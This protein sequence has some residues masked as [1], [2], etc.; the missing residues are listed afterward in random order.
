MPYEP[1]PRTPLPRIHVV[2]RGDTLSTL[3]GK[4]YGDIG[5]ASWQ[6]I[7]EA[8]REIIGDDPY[9]MELTIPQ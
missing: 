2:Q 1:A 9:R 7:F 5:V 6:R 8:N 4:F 3:A